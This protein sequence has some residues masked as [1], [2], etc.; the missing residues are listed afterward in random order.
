[1]QIDAVAVNLDAAGRLFQQR[2]VQ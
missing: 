2:R 1:M